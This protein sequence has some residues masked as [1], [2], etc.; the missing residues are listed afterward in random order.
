[1]LSV[2]RPRLAAAQLAL[3]PVRMV[4]TSK[5]AYDLGVFL[6]QEYDKAR[7]KEK[8]MNKRAEDARERQLKAKMEK[9]NRK[10]VSDID[11]QK[12]ENTV[13]ELERQEK[14]EAFLKKR[15][16][17][18][19]WCKLDHEHGPQCRQPVHGCSHDHQKEW[20]IYEKSTE[21]KIRGADRFRQ[22]GNDAFKQNNYGLAAV[23][24]RKALLQFD[25]TFP[26]GDEETKWLDDV[27]IAC[28]LNLAACKCQQEEWDEVVTHCRLALEINPRS[29]KAYYRTAQAH[30]ARDAFEEAKDTL[31]TAYEIEPNNNDVRALLR[32]LKANMANY[33][34]REK[35]VY[36]A[37]TAATTDAADEQRA[38]ERSV[39]AQEPEAEK[40]A[41]E[42][43]QEPAVP[44]A[45]E[46]AP[47]AS[48]ESSPEF[49]GHPS[50]PPN[51]Q[52]SASEPSMRRRRGDRGADKVAQDN[53]DA[54]EE[55][56]VAE[57]ASQTKMLNRIFLAA[58]VLGV[59]S[60]SVVGFIMYMGDG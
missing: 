54:E 17:A 59:V 49:P 32:K 53:E 48:V 31:L 52:A 18:S 23:H 12:H 57:L 37:M 41:E 21:E 42:A 38:E 3:A 28:L 40:A 60:L 8:D 36:E 27:K 14:E 13:K 29:V 56:E 45:A 5:E 58:G 55:D 33:Q 24:Y 20:A 6:T 51:E 11:Y 47:A 43:V 44:S 39:A 30:I 34:V 10:Q 9:D 35:Q 50:T 19:L 2:G 26:E 7:A 1:M 4:A 16:E 22:E 46:D 25:Y 15:Q